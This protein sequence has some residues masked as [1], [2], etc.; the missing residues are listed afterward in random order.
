M[1][2]PLCVWEGGKGGGGGRTKKKEYA[3]TCATI[4]H[5]ATHVQLTGTPATATLPATV[6]LSEREAATVCVC[7]C[8]CVCV[9]MCARVCG[10]C[11]FNLR[12]F[13]EE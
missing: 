1:L 4:L 8:V 3:G 2:V 9:C 10:D 6:T 11:V 13:I 5:D 12:V 7:M